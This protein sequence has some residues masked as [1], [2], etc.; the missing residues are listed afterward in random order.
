[1]TNSHLSTSLI[2]IIASILLTACQTDVSVNPK[3]K[4]T[5]TAQY[6]LNSLVSEIET[7]LD[8][9]FRASIQALDMLGY[10]RTGEA[11]KDESVTIFSR[12]VGD[13][14]IV[15]KITQI[16]VEKVQ[17]QIRIGIFGSLPESQTILSEIQDII[18][19]Q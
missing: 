14:Q 13:E 3:Q 7:D 18:L 6:Q 15:L 12:K 5:V 11:Y 1:M 4:N 16:S 10:F 17:I 9:A 19:S 8:N 2:A